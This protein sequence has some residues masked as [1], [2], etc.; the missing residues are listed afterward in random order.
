MSDG[1]FSGKPRTQDPIGS[2]SPSTH[3]RLET[4]NERPDR[5]RRGRVETA[6]EERD[7]V[8]DETD[9]DWGDGRRVGPIPLAIVNLSVGEDDPGPLEGT[10]EVLRGRTEGGTA[11]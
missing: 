11:P 10:R 7:R 2:L 4:W 9:Q 1:L 5:V 8:N 3:R 6:P